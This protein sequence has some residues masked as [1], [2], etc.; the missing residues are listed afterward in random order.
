MNFSKDPYMSEICK[1]KL[2]PKYE[3]DKCKIKKKKLVFNQMSTKYNT[4][5]TCFVCSIFI[6]ISS[7]LKIINR[8]D[9]F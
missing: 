4:M 9:F 5:S 1:I 8:V 2:I 7:H 3:K 6:D